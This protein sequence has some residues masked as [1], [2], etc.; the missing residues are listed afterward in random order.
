[1]AEERKTGLFLIRTAMVTELDNVVAN[2]IDWDE[3]QQAAI[4]SSTAIR[5]SDRSLQSA[6]FHV[7]ATIG[8]YA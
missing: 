6:R 5:D 7:A 3:A 4:S 8:D 1:M 2:E